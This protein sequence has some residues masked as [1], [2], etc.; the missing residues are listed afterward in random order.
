MQ[1]ND[2]TLYDRLSA[3]WWEPRGTLNQLT[4][5]NPLRLAYFEEVV[6]AFRDKTILDIGCGGGL[7]TEEFAKRGACITGLD[8]SLKSLFQAKTHAVENGL[9]IDYRLGNA[10]GLSFPDKSFD[11][12]VGE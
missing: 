10:A 8:T 4:D 2:L 5:F 9:E 1:R 11:I 6:G 12:V 3:T 7:L